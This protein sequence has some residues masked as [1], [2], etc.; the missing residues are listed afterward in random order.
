ML[1][2]Q[3]PCYFPP[4]CPTEFFQATASH[5]RHF[6]FTA[7]NSGAF[8]SYSEGVIR[9]SLKIHGAQVANAEA[10]VATR[11]QVGIGLG[12]HLGKGIVQQLQHT[13]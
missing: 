5:T 3:Q 7:T 4:A 13:V 6:D 10:V 11:D 2:H 8:P 12:G 9:R 1:H